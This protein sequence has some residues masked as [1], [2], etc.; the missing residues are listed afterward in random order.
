MC[1][2][3]FFLELPSSQLKPSQLDNIFW[4]CPFILYVY[5]Q[6]AHKSRCYFH[7]RK[8]NGLHQLPAMDLPLNLAEDTTLNLHKNRIR[9]AGQLKV[10]VRRFLSVNSIIPIWVPKSILGSSNIKY[11]CNLQISILLLYQLVSVARPHLTKQC[12]RL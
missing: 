3:Q 6:D 5:L 11:L 7:F 9:V 12:R 8:Y 10:M 4:I 1:L 2:I